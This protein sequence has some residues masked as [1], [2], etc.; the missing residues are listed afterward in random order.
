MDIV[1]RLILDDSQINTS[2]K[3]LIVLLRKTGQNFGEIQ[4]EIS[5]FSSATVDD[6]RQVV[7]AEEKALVTKQKLN[8]QETEEWA[9]GY[10][11]RLKIL[12]DWEKDLIKAQELELDIARKQNAT[13]E[14]KKAILEK[15][16]KLWGEYEEAYRQNSDTLNSA[17][18]DSVEKTITTVGE[19]FNNLFSSIGGFFSGVANTLVDKFQAGSKAVGD[20]FF[21][22][23]DKIKNVQIGSKS[24]GQLGESIGNLGFKIS[25]TVKGLLGFKQSLKEN[26]NELADGAKKSRLMEIASNGLAKAKGALAGGFRLAS[27]AAKAFGA[28]LIATG[29]G[30]VVK[31]LAELMAYLQRTQ[32]GM[33]L[34]GKVAAYVSGFLGKFGDEIA[35]LGEGIVN[36]FENPKQAISDLWEFLKTNLLNRVQAIP[37]LFVAVGKVMGSAFSLDWDGVKKGMGD[38][39]TAT[40]QLTT[41][42]DELQQQNAA[43][44]FKDTKDAANEAGLAMV[45]LKKR[46]V[47]LEIATNA[48][49]LKEAQM[50]VAL[51]KAKKDADDITLG[52][53][54]RI[55]AAK[56]AVSLEEGILSGRLRIA[57]ETLSIMEAEFS[58][59]EET[60]EQQ[61]QLA[62]ARAEVAKLTAESLKKQ[63]E[64]QEKVNQLLKEAENRYKAVRNSIVSELKELELLNPEIEFNIVKEGK[65]EE[66]Q[67]NK[68][69]L[70]DQL[71]LMTDLAA[72]AQTLQEKEDYTKRIAQIKEYS[73]YNEDLLEVWANKQW[74]Q[75]VWDAIFIDDVFSA[76]LKKSIAEANKEIEKLKGKEALYGVSFA[77]E[78]EEQEKIKE[79]LEAQIK[80]AGILKAIIKG[81]IDFDV[82]QKK[83]L[84]ELLFPTN[85]EI[86]SRLKMIN[87][88]TKKVIDNID[89]ELNS[90]ETKYSRVKELERQ[91]L[92]IILQSLMQQRAAYK[93]TVNEETL[94]LD[95]QIRKLQEQLGNMPDPELPFE[96]AQEAWEF[97]LEEMFG[98]NAAGKIGKFVAGAAVAFNEFNALIAESQQIQIE[99]IDKQLEKLS[100]KREELEGALDYELE[101][102]EQG[103]ANNVGD[104]QKEVDAILAEE[105]RLNKEKEAIQ[106][107]AQ[108]RQFAIDTANQAQALITSAIQIYKGFS[109]I[110]F[111][112]GIPL[113]VGTIAAMFSFFAKTK[114]DAFKATRLSTGADRISDHFGYGERYGATDLEGRGAG[115][116]LINEATGKPTNVIISG[117]EMIL[118]ERFSLEHELFFQKMKSGAYNGMDLN[119]ALGFYMNYKN[120]GAGGSVMF[121]NRTI[122]IK[123]KPNR[124]WIPFVTKDGKSGAV[125]RTVNEKEKDG[126]TIYFDI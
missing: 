124:Q 65:L 62:Q 111:G 57:K 33:D 68:K 35:K 48:L 88:S 40:I 52:Y 6:I 14:E 27:G 102:R 18:S 117:R 70:E 17:I 63:A 79:K 21:N 1:E 3:E 28:A 101:L 53:T 15:Y 80:Q 37:A 4:K 90:E 47:E 32:K 114:I 20:F 115:Y 16:V 51:E 41:G 85:S 67:K 116:R 42:M 64:L 81:E 93:L 38:V 5:K 34:V 123:E 103:L 25:S 49:I 119:A 94:A 97:L 8:R 24:V 91:K 26:N 61:G 106:E 12:K 95:E 96:N 126:S 83:K 69:E 73:K 9:K 22:V 45:E 118:P 121:E 7:L 120:K 113:A 99:N 56:K 2:L 11:A 109:T 10:R 23:G 89:E 112:L 31:L 76:K 44:W 71:A 54:K 110:P 29:I 104:K 107:K 84:S 66:L 108:K 50:E 125:L 74:R 46:K 58:L 59:G 75:N 60:R 105:D 13:V 77:V 36:A 82:I 100:E 92:E 122:S 43:Q 87:A 55:E 19:K 30:L 39:T 72:K 86:E 98:K 78:I